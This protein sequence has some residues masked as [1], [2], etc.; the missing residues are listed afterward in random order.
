[1]MHPAVY[2]S[3]PRLKAGN[4]EKTS[5][6]DLNY[7]CIAHAAEDSSRWWWPTIGFAGLLPPGPQP[8]RYWPPG[9][10]HAETIESFVL[11][12]ESIG[13]ERC[14]DGQLETGWQKIAIY[15]LGPKPTHAA[16]QLDSGE[17]TS[18]MGRVEDIRHA[19]P[20]DVAGGLYGDVVVFMRRR[21]LAI[22]A[23]DA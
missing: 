18:K 4:H 17:W 12:Y 8:K 11:A 3:C 16:R 14:D 20:E 13:Y 19:K 9:V 5:E 10:P 7:N 21:R 23:T 6:R 1:M 15:A 2:V 22:A